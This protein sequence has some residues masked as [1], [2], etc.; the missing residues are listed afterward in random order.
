M[1]LKEWKT[2]NTN[3]TI[4]KWWGFHVQIKETLDHKSKYISTN[5]VI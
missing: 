4:K 3:Q 1:K 5:S 2:N